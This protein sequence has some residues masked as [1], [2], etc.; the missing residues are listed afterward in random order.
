MS[1]FLQTR[2]LRHK[3]GLV[4]VAFKEKKKSQNIETSTNWWGKKLPWE[5][6]QFTAN[7]TEA[8]NSAVNLLPCSKPRKGRKK[9]SGAGGGGGNAIGQVG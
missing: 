3:D 1:L 7:L 2:K 8:V 4:S 6:Q 9:G 5:D